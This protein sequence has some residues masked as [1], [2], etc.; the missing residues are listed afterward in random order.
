MESDV[1]E[2]LGLPLFKGLTQL[3]QAHP[4]P[5]FLINSEPGTLITSAKS[6]HSCRTYNVNT[7][8]RSHHLHRIPW[9]GSGPRVLSTL[10]G[11]GLRWEEQ[12]RGDLRSIATLI[13]LAIILA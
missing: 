12:E 3:N 9:A 6:C 13:L 1:R 5:L 8:V 10:E 11:W 4:E 2:G 7:G